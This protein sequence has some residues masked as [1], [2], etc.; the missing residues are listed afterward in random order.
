MASVAAAVAEYDA[1]CEAHGGAG[2]FA[3]EADAV[4]RLRRALDVAFED[5]ER[6][7]SPLDALIDTARALLDD[8]PRSSATVLDERWDETRRASTRATRALEAVGDHAVAG[9]VR[10]ADLAGSPDAEAVACAVLRAFARAAESPRDAFVAVLERLHVR[11][12]QLRRQLRRGEPVHSAA[13]ALGWRLAA[14]CLRAMPTLLARRRRDPALHALDADPL[15]RSVEAIAIEAEAHAFATEGEDEGLPGT[16]E[17]TSEGTSGRVWASPAEALE[18]ARA[19]RRSTLRLFAE[20]ASP[21]DAN[22]NANANAN[23]REGGKYAKDTTDARVVRLCL[24]WLARDPSPETLRLAAAATRARRADD[25]ETLFRVAT[26]VESNDV[27]DS[28]TTHDDAD[29]TA[30]LSV[31]GAVVLAGAWLVAAEEKTPFPEPFATDIASPCRSAE[32]SFRKRPERVAE[33]VAAA[34]AAADGESLWETVPSSSR[35]SVRSALNAAVVHFAAVAFRRCGEK[36]AAPREEDVSLKRGNAAPRRGDD[37]K[38]SYDVADA[39][40]GEARRR[41]AFARALVALE[42]RV[43]RAPSPAFREL[44]RLAH[45]RLLTGVDDDAR[46]FLL[47]RRIAKTKTKT[48]TETKTKTSRDPDASPAMRALYVS[49]LRRETHRALEVSNGSRD[50]KTNAPSPFA[51]AEVVDLVLDATRGAIR[52]LSEAASRIDNRADVRDSASVELP[53]SDEDADALVAGLNFFRFVL[54]RARGGLLRADDMRRDVAGVW[55]RRALVETHVAAPAAAWARSTLARLDDGEGASSLAKAK[56]KTEEGTE[57]AAA[58][59]SWRRRMGA[60]HVLEAAR[61]VSELC[62]DP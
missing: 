43:E 46:F 55:S 58:L 42:M 59:R 40:V 21:Y 29:A 62:D 9:F 54:G 4:D 10:V 48:K 15:V 20:Y 34:F 19:Y 1:W 52:T 6:S 57:D 17:G 13:E 12:E 22:A 7:S 35:D 53:E 37:E 60:E 14:E 30:P 28:I 25:V 36:G 50:P 31:V 44:A 49:R 23:A 27:G 2:A 45:A 26:T 39:D 16:S 3:E 11:A 56:K 47:A 18:A 8:D 38:D 24:E 51:R 41:R 33:H 5:A 61:F 32:A